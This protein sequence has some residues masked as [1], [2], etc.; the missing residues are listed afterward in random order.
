[1][2]HAQDVMKL[3]KLTGLGVLQCKFMLDDA[4]SLDVAIKRIEDRVAP[5]PF[6]SYSGICPECGAGHRSGT[7]IDCPNCDW[8]RVAPNDRTKWDTVGRCPS[9]GFAYRWDGTV[10]SHCGHDAAE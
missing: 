8:V 5:I 1:M 10:C 2:S 9:C 4:G 3:R 7:Q 6:V